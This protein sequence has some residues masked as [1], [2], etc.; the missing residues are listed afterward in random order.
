MATRKKSLL[1]DPRVVAAKVIQG[2]V[3]G[4]S[5]SELMPRYLEQLDDLR[6]G[7]LAQ[8]I[9]YGVIR[10]YPQLKALVN[11]LL[12]RPLKAK[13]R[14]VEA[15]IMIGLYQLLYLRVAEHAALNETA[16]AAK[17]L[18]KSWAV[19]LVNG[20]LR[21]FQRRREALM[22]QIETDPQ[23]RHAMPEWLLQRVQQ[24]WPDAWQARVEALNSR[25]PMSLRINLSAISRETYLQRLKTQGFLAQPI[26]YTQGGVTL[27]KA[28]EV[29][30]LPGFDEGCISVQDGA[31]QLAAELLDLKP[32]LQVLDACAAPGG[33][34]C[35]LLERERKLKLTAMDVNPERLVRVEENLARLKLQAEVVAGDAAYPAGEWASRLYERILL[36]VP[37]SAT[38]VMRRHPDIKLLR[39]EEDIPNLVSL[40]SDILKAIWPRL[41]VGG[42][43]LYVTCSILSEENEQQLE[44]FLSEHADAVEQPLDVAW[45]EARTVGRQ[46]APGVKGMDGFFYARLVK[47]CSKPSQ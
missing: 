34:S 39:R 31:A 6:D 43:M 23:A 18:G 17:K 19:G 5:L 36:D 4:Q 20:V 21:N 35:H 27:E 44:R 29:T 1:K 38:G 3:A 12:D 22:D 47:L 41:A 14:D 28:M 10:R 2:V 25:P 33:K 30:Q 32:G 9:S 37:C 11:C 13:D 26:P 42:V 24:Q 16:G 46:I 8:E 45:G 7:G 40:Q 15:L